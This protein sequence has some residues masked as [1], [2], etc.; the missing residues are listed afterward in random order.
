M[1]AKLV[2]VCLL[3]AI[4]RFDGIFTLYPLAK[5]Y[6]DIIDKISNVNDDKKLQ[7]SEDSSMFLRVYCKEPN[8]VSISLTPTIEFIE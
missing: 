2:F 7:T 4:A 8:V 5:D 1:L 6:F 3:L